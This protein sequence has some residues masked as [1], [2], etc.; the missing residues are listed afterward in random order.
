MILKNEQ[1]NCPSAVHTTP[2]AVAGTYHERSPIASNHYTEAD[3]KR[4]EEVVKCVRRG[5]EH[6]LKFETNNPFGPFEAIYKNG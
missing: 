5:F 6:N 1:K 3:E 2:R 4:S